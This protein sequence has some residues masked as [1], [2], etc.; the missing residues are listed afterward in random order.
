MKKTL[1]CTSV[2]CQGHRQGSA[3]VEMAIIVPIF[4]MILF[5]GIEF[6]RVCLV[7][8]AANN[9][10][11][12]SARQMMVPG[13]TLTDAQAE[14]GRLLTVLGVGTYTLTVTPDPVTTSTDRVTVRIAIP[15]WQNGWVS[16]YFCP[17]LTIQ[18]GST[19]FTERDR[20]N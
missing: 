17:N 16:A 14:A 7:R 6:S 2:R 15:A 8:N 1:S 20:G 13:A 4:F 5:A 10:A 9:A 18:A 11:Y 19:L 3:M 12:Q